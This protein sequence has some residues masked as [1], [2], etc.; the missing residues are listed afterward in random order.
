MSGHAGAPRVTAL[1]TFVGRG[2]R[3]ALLAALLGVALQAQPQPPTFSA[4]NRTVAV[5]ATVTDAGGRL[6]PDLGRSQFQID[7]NDNLVQV[8]TSAI[9][10]SANGIAIVFQK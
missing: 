2:V 8:V 1:R 7:D 9:A 10:A 4:G 6:V 5:Y 3:P